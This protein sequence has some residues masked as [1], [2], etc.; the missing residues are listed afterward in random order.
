[1]DR[2]KAPLGVEPYNFE[3]TFS[4]EEIAARVA[5]AEQRE[6]AAAASDTDSDGD[7]PPPP[8]VPDR[9]ANNEWCRCNYCVPLDQPRQCRCC[10]EVAICRRF[11]VDCITQH[12]DFAAVCLHKAVLRTALVARLDTRGHRARLPEELD[13]E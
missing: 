7:P 9:M 1:M 10:K 2:S 4:E 3:P 8:P 5:E 11:G 12:E 13:S 6:A